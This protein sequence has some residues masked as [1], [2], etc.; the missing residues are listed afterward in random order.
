M[1]PLWQPQAQKIICETRP[2]SQINGKVEY[3]WR[4]GNALYLVGSEGCAI[5]WAAKTGWNRTQLI[6]LK[7]AIAEKRPEY[8]TRHEAIIFHHDNARP[9]VAIPVKNYLENSEWE[10][11]AHPPHSPDLAPSDYHFFRSMQN[12]LLE[13]GSHQNRVSKICL[14]FLGRQAGA[15]LLGWNPQIAR[16][17]GKSHSFRWAMLWIILLYMF[18]LNKISNFEKKPHESSY[19]SNTI[20]SILYVRERDCQIFQFILFCVFCFFYRLFAVSYNL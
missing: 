15:V 5:L 9:H 2:T 14:I 8:A 19:R 7:K 11:L 18:L 6:R 10:V 3:P 1:D 16:K 17:M 13:Y 4:K 20:G 12:A